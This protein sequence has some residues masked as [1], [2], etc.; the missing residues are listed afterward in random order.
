MA[1]A[2]VH[3]SFL[4]LYKDVHH[5]VKEASELWK[6]WSNNRIFFLF[7]K[8]KDKDDWRRAYIPRPSGR[9]IMV[10]G[11]SGWIRLWFV[12]SFML[13]DFKII[14]KID[15]FFSKK[16]KRSRWMARFLQRRRFFAMKTTPDS[17]FSWFDCLCLV[18]C[19]VH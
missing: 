15:Y 10:K 14:N 12:R 1:F 7:S 11:M 9:A 2:I 3:F 8:L 5:Y 13:L 18:E 6:E 19:R 17:H 4:I 16:K